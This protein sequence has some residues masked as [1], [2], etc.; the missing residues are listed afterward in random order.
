MSRAD[1]VERAIL[2]IRKFHELGHA[3]SP[4]EP[5]EKAWGGKRKGTG[6]EV[7]VPSQPKWLKARQFAEQYP[8]ATELDKLLTLI[9][10][11]QS[12]QPEG[13]PV[14]GLSHVYLLVTVPVSSPKSRQAILDLTV[15]KHWSTKRMEEEIRKRFG[16]R[17]AGGR[18][19]H[20]APDKQA[21]YADTDRMCEQWRRWTDQ[22]RADKAKHVRLT[23]LPEHVQALVNKAAAAVDE[24]QQAV[25]HELRK[26]RHAFRGRPHL[27]AGSGD[28]KQTPTDAGMRSPKA[29]GRKL[30]RAK[31]KRP[32]ARGLELWSGLEHR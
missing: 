23:D 1:E 14:F 18:K 20:I 29:K 2:A 31:P 5:Q 17:R 30:K 9:H 8:T 11:V 4:R 15:R 16:T 12:T 21:F 32:P 22:L 6:D 13:A 10:K 3:A 26:A 28:A 24:L 19:R 27:E 25:F 7:P